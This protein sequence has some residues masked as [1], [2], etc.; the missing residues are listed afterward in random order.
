MTAMKSVIQTQLSAYALPVYHGTDLY[1]ESFESSAVGTYGAGIYFADTEESAGSYGGS[2]ITAFVRL[3]NPW[4]IDVDFESEG[5]Y[6]EDFDHPAIEAIL[7]LSQG[8]H[9]LDSAKARGHTLFDRALQ[10]ELISLGHDGVV[11]TYPD[12]SKELVAFSCDQIEI[13]CW[14]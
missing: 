10:G 9:L 2:I 5:A 14:K 1:F 11:A 7:S 6:L 3:N 4:V 8:R 13:I 12:G